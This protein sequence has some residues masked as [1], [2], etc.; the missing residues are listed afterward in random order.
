MN[1]EELRNQQLKAYREGQAQ[2]ASQFPSYNST[3]KVPVHTLIAD[4]KKLLNQITALNIGNLNLTGNTQQM[5]SRELS[6][7]VEQLYLLMK[8]IKVDNGYTGKII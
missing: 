1:T 4:A 2:L 5:V 8:Q 7:K 6:Q 3:Q